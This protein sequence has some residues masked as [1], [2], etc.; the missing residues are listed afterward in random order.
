MPTYNRKGCQKPTGKP[1]SETLLLNHQL[2]SM[3]LP[4]GKKNKIT[5]PAPEESTV[6]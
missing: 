3:T 1:E 2:I 5:A 4:D 6:I